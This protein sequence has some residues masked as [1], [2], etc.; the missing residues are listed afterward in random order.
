MPSSAPRRFVLLDR[1]GTINVERNY[2]SD[3]DQLALYPGVGPA[4]RRLSDLGF[5]IAVVTNQSGIA[6]GYF[7]LAQLERVHE[8][9]RAL[10]AEFGVTIDGIFCCPHAPDA[11]C[12]C[13]KPLPGM[14]EQA[15]AALGFDP[16][17][18]FM[19]GDKAIDVELGQ[20][21]GAKSILV[22][23]GYGHEQEAN[24]AADAVVDDLP[25]AVAWIERSVGTA[26]AAE[27]L[28]Q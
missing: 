4:L 21:V 20:G 5:G 2:L 10:L 11:G 12:D 7:D 27:R 9:L 13:R 6:R 16:K 23:T 19:V 1:D 25:A 3:P 15:V 26:K 24:C 14:I 17:Q 22:R 8:R 18:A 28:E